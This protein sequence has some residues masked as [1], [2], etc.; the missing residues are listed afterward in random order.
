[1][2]TNTNYLQALTL[3]V[4]Q[5]ISISAIRGVAPSNRIAGNVSPEIT[6]IVVNNAT[7]NSI[8]IN[9]VTDFQF[10]TNVQVNQDAQYSGPNFGRQ[11][12]FQNSLATINVAA[13]PS[14][15]NI[16]NTFDNS[17]VA[18][19]YS[20]LTFTVTNYTAQPFTVPGT[21]SWTVPAGVTNINVA[22]IGAGGGGVVTFTGGAGGGGGLSNY[23][24][25]LKVNPGDSYTIVVGAGGISGNSRGVT[26]GDTYMYPANNVPI[27]TAGGGA[28]GN[29]MFWQYPDRTI[30]NE[31][32]SGTFS[33]QP[34]ID[35][36]NGTITY[37]VSVGSLPSNMSLN[38][39][40]G[41]L[42]WT[43]SGL[44]TTGNANTS[45]IYGPITLSATNGTVTVT[46]PV[47]LVVNSNPVDTYFTATQIALAMDN[48]A[49]TFIKDVSIYNNQGVASGFVTPSP[50]NP[51]NGSYYSALFDGSTGFLTVST[52]TNLDI[53]SQSFSV[54][55]WWYS[56]VTT[57]QQFFS[58][59]TDFWLSVDYNT[60][61]AGRLGLYASTNGTSWD[62]ITAAA[63]GNGISTGV[64]SLGQWNHI[65]LSRSVGN[66]SM[67]LNGN[68]ILTLSGLSNALITR[69]G[70]PK[71]IGASTSAGTNK[72]NGWM[73]GFK[74][75]VGTATYDPTI[76]SI[77]VPT[78]P[79]TT[80]T[81]MKLLILQEP[82]FY[83]KTGST[84][85]VTVSGIVS[86]TPFYPYTSAV[87]NANT[88][89]L[90]KNSAYFT[91]ATDYVNYT[92]QPA[93]PLIGPGDFT[94]EAWVYPISRAATMPVIINTYDVSQSG[95]F[96]LYAGHSAASLTKWSALIG[97]GTPNLISTATIN[98]RQWSHVAISRIG[99]T[100]TFYINGV[101]DASTSTTATTPL[102]GTGPY[103]VIG[104]SWDSTNAGSSNLFFTGYI[105]NLRTVN[106]IG[107][108]TGSF[109]IPAN[110][111]SVTQSS[112]SNIQAISTNTN[113]TLLT[114]QNIGPVNNLILQDNSDYNN[115]I[116]RVGT[117]ALGSFNPYRQLTSSTYFNG[118][119]A[120]YVGTASS[121]LAFA[122]GT[123]D[124]T[125][126]AWVLPT[127]NAANGPGT[128]FDLRTIAG[129]T[130]IVGRFNA[131]RQMVLD[132]AVTV[133][134]TPE[135]LTMGVWS[136]VAWSRVNGIF[137]GYI[138]GRLTGSTTYA[139]DLGSTSQPLYIGYNW[140][141]AY[142]W[143]GYISNF[144]I[145]KGFGIYSENY[146]LP[147]STPLTSIQSS[148]TSV[149]A[150]N[151][152]SYTSVLTL[153]NSYVDNSTNNFLLST[154]GNPSSEWQSPFVIP[155]TYASYTP[156][157]GGSAYFNGTT[158]Y[159]S[160]ANSP[161]LVLSAST[162]TASTTSSWT[163]ECWVKPI[164]NYTA[165][166]IIYSKR[167][168]AGT[169][170]YE[171]GLAITTGFV[172]FS[173][174]A[175]VST[176]AFVPR[177]GV[178]THLAWVFNGST[179]WLKMYANG[180]LIF[181]AP[182]LLISEINTALQIGANFTPAMYY[183]GWISDLRVV[184]GIAVYETPSPLTSTTNTVVFTP[185]VSKLTTTQSAGTN[186]AAISNSANT[187]LLLNFNSSA[188]YD[189]AAKNNIVTVNSAQLSS[190]SY[191]YG[192]SSA[193]F[194]YTAPT[195]TGGQ[196]ITDYLR[197]P[198]AATVGTP[199]SQILG[200]DFTV[201][202]WFNA[203]GFRVGNYTAL[204]TYA[205]RYQV[206]YDCR[207]ASANA[208]G[209]FVGT[210]EQ[211]Q[212]IF[213]TNGSIA[214]TSYIT[215]RA[216]TW[217]HVA[218]VRFNGTITLYLN[219]Q[220]IG[221]VFNT[222][223]FTDNQSVIGVSYADSLYQMDGYIDELRITKLAR[224]TSSF[225]PP[226]RIKGK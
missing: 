196:A 199:G 148:R 170:S 61:G 126:E 64:P 141:A 30:T 4:N 140:T 45:T 18:L 37:S 116:T 65:A 107:L 84:A 115:L 186:I 29:N 182:S 53:L 220:N 94:V 82:W 39:S 151:T 98:F 118:V 192:S 51:F 40:S 180:T 23:E 217:N 19:N 175:I 212:L 27:I 165:N 31:D 35:P 109:T 5:Q 80:S 215:S 3:V 32:I 42:T 121:I 8:N 195:G 206:H 204:S 223:V 160:V 119:N 214:I 133:T 92:N 132:G 71:I 178:W 105:S 78:A 68:R 147:Q 197:T 177:T 200:S 134:F 120:T 159:F 189:L 59:N 6:Q 164:G 69:I 145:I 106:G 21:Y 17:S 73:T 183:Y 60:L 47:Y 102:N 48:T 9:R 58:S 142:G 152:A 97:S 190:I 36:A 20:G 28:G 207:T 167:T 43:E 213:Y 62:L 90:V 138:N 112:G 122:L 63:G 24:N 176:S 154:G 198:L 202:Y 150:M 169:G 67:W 136:H 13:N 89:T 111:L 222:T 146:F 101:T 12:L 161:P 173:Y 211:G 77:T 14:S 218:L 15:A 185:P 74:F 70:E 72:V 54:E 49:T 188:I 38:S 124:F 130:A 103:I 86:V 155:S 2:A 163:I 79:L 26:G 11:T 221:S 131:Q 88:T 113:T 128:V 34:A 25:N 224:Y 22:A 179:T 216:G 117:P 129:A 157:E 191:K 144:R 187:S 57:R 87:A 83:D 125:I 194:P 193:Y 50:L 181:T 123:G 99:N 91:A 172:Y 66:W 143:N 174:N 137:Y 184:K 81:N 226:Y 114:L 56:E 149:R 41:V 110:P 95:S 156:S 209:F 201:E 85:T 153:Q 203:L 104:N 1:M 139:N 93:V 225:I 108:Y 135:V 10:S 168:A 76:T 171:G 210:T 219:G 166:N 96:A 55:F 100:A 205:F 208:T 127:V 44:A 33:A 162:A 46:K 158:D 7:R 16:Y 52:G 75:V